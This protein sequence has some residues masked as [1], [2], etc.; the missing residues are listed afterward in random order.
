MLN[1]YFNKFKSLIVV[2]II[3]TIFAIVNTASGQ[4]IFNYKQRPPA[5][6][7]K[8]DEKFNDIA[9]FS[10]SY[11][12]Q[13]GR[14]KYLLCG[15]DDEKLILDIIK[16]NP[17]QKEFYFLDV[18]AG[19]FQWVKNVFKFL[20]NN[21]EVPKNK[22]YHII[23]VNGEGKDK[24]KIIGNFTIYKLGGFKIENII[25][26]FEERNIKINGKIDLIVSSWTLRHLADPL[27][28]FFQMHQL[29]KLNGYI[30]LEGIPFLR[31]DTE[32]KHIYNRRFITDYNLNAEH[33][34]LDLKQTY[35][36][37]PSTKGMDRNLRGIMIIKSE[38]D[39]NALRSLS[40]SESLGLGIS[41]VNYNCGKPDTTQYISKN[42]TKLKSKVT[43]TFEYHAYNGDRSLHNTLKEKELF[44]LYDDCNIELFCRSNYRDDYY[45][46]LDFTND[47][48]IDR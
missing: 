12:T 29:T 19:R 36:M 15:I 35:L 14:K 21:S 3:L 28:T 10:K 9:K 2:T 34:L 39:Q 44:Y 40:Y 11:W 32:G 37:C 26:A 25:E 33:L 24:I 7:K 47:F 13:N 31:L 23:G 27:G 1:Y 8:I 5:V 38:I 42:S 16:Q 18:G 22:K 20:T 6:Q 43:S 46:K 4:D 41:D 45:Y 17:D 48:I 30:L